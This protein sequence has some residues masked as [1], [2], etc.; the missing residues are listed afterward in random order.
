MREILF[1][2]NICH[3]YFMYKCLLLCILCCRM[4]A[5]QDT[6]YWLQQFGPRSTVL[7]GSNAATGKD[8]SAIINNPAGLGFNKQSNISITTNAYAMG[9]TDV[10][11][12][13]GLVRI[14]FLHSIASYRLLFRVC[15]NIKNFQ[16]GQ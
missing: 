14:Y 2:R 16:N 3:I 6:H 8:N 12:G 5:A 1:F 9:T 7:N 10:K 4:A 13:A 15:I 11:N